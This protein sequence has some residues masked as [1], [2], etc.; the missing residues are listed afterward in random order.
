MAPS[1]RRRAD[2]AYRGGVHPRQR[3]LPPEIEE[4][5]LEALADAELGGDQALVYVVDGE[6]GSTG[7]GARYL[8]PGLYIRPDGEADEIR[9]LLDEM[10]DDS[11]ID[12]YRVVVFTERTPEG[13]AALIR[14]ELEHARQ[15]DAHGQRLTGLY[16]IAEN[17][18][19]E[20]VGGLDGGGFLYHWKWTPTPRLPSLSGT[21]S[22]SSGS[23]SYCA[24]TTKTVRHSAHSS[25]R[26]R[27]R[28]CPS[29]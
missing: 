26:R 24:R 5:W 3:E 15:R 28:R 6:K 7:Y 16:D 11:C 12:A 19:S 18:I 17:V 23:M 4:V 8:H 25:D 14:H 13:I 9:P 1:V 22:A 20:R 27:S 2:A 10:N 29:G 21:G